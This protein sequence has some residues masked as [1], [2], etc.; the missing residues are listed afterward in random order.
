MRKPLETLLILGMLVAAAGCGRRVDPRAEDIYDLVVANEID[1]AVAGANAI[2]ADEPDNAQIRN[3]LG[4]ALYKSGDA[5]GSIEQYLEALEDDSKYPECWFNLGNSYKVLGRAQEA[6]N[7]FEKAIEH[8]KKFDVARLNLGIIYRDT[9]RPDLALE[10]W[11]QAVKDNDQFD[12]A[13][14]E[15]GLLESQR[16]NVDAAIPA[17]ERVLE[18]RPTAKQVR[19]HLGN[20]YLTSGRDGA[21]QLA[22]NEYRA[23][24][25]I[26]PEY[27]DGLY[28]LAV[29]LAAQERH[30]EALATFEKVWR[31]TL[32]RPEHPIHKRIQDYFKTVGYTPGAE[33]AEG[34]EGTESG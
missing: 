34:D 23:A 14:L 12:L 1:Q 28:S 31:L 16:G 32:D 3:V 33:D 30:D 13:Y 24:I 7:A 25:G 17:F 10:Q 15:I 6:E 20:A 18:L 27:V 26:D 5:E 21:S 2:L 9:G 29:A 4:L 8:E 22:E 11:R 19:V